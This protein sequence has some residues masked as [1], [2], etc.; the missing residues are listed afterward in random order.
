LVIL[1]RHG[2][3]AGVPVRSVISI[4]DDDEASREALAVLI[5]SLGFVGESFESAAAFLAWP[6]RAETA[7]LI[8]DI[9]MPGMTG[10]EL[11]RH[12]VKVGCR[13]P[14]ILITAYP[15]DAGRARALADG[16]IAY[17]SKPCSEYVL[18]ECVQS[19]LQLGKADHDLS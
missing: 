12:L 8:A 13:I 11:H 17:L 1:H 15:E 18:L 3:S 9:N 14:T 10:V 5:K 19:A 4:V 7:C 16:V 2:Y 6:R